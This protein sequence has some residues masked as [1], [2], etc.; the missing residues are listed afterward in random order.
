LPAGH[1]DRRWLP[2]RPAA[3]AGSRGLTGLISLVHADLAT[4]RP[5]PLSYAIVLGTGYWD[6]AVFAAAA[7]AVMA[8]GVLAWEAFTEAARLDRPQLPAQWCLRPGEPATLLPADF[9]VLI[10]RPT[11]RERGRMRQVLARRLAAELG[12]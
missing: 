11:D 6:R 3:E 10:E 5:E 9:E 7:G 4:W 1:P 12:D 2:R 8:G